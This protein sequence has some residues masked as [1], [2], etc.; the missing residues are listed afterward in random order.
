MRFAALCSA[1]LLVAAACQPLI[2]RPEPST[3]MV[4]TEGSIF[5]RD[6]TPGSAS[7]PFTVENR[8]TSTLY[9]ARCG[10]RLMAAV[11]RWENGQWVQHSGDA[12]QTVYPMDARPLAPSASFSSARQVSAPGRYRLRLDARSAPTLPSEWT[13]AVSNEFTVE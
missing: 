6:A 2:T 4:L 12:C 10:E 13:T 7:V 3:I 1:V 9:L 11:D 5:V 8:G